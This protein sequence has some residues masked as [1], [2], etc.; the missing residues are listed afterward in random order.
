MYQM[1]DLRYGK[2][3]V[4]EKTVPKGFVLDENVYPVFIEENG[5]TYNVENEHTQ[6]RGNPHHV[7]CHEQL[8]V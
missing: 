8:K 7:P 5:K 3:L 6:R 2:Y 4:R 1:D